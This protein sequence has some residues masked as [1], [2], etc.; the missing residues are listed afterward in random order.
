MAVFTGTQTGNVYRTSTSL[1]SGGEA[2]VCAVD[3]VP[4]LALK[5]YRRPTDLRRRKV[6]ALAQR[7][8][9]P[10]AQ[11]R[12]AW[13]LET[14]T[15]AQGRFAGFVMRRLPAGCVPLFK[16][17]ETQGAQKLGLTARDQIQVALSL[18]EA[19][20]EAHRL[21]V[22]IGD[23]NDENAVVDLGTKRVLLLDCDGY[24]FGPW[25]ATGWTPEG[26]APETHRSVRQKTGFYYDEYTDR[27]TLADHIF[28]LL[29]DGRGPFVCRTTD[30]SLNRPS[31]GQAIEE[32]AF[33]YD[34]P[35]TVAARYPAIGVPLGAPSYQRLS[36]DVR[37]LF[38]RAFTGLPAQRPTAV[39]WQNALRRMLGVLA[40]PN[41]SAVRH[42]PAKAKIT[43]RKRT[44]KGRRTQAW[45]NAAQTH[46]KPTPAKPKRSMPT[47]LRVSLIFF[48]A[49]LA[50]SCAS[51]GCSSTPHEELSPGWVVVQEG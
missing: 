39:E 7:L 1:G 47:A 24:V 37:A 22:S 45:K 10:G 48:A 51:H 46:Q 6:E 15:N 29:M 33:V 13:P 40:A 23:A 19:Y 42:T 9:S 12:F 41:P 43:S 32:G 49:A 2:T 16:V 26:S 11:N 50:L 20:G 27:F 8:P 28:R 25:E 34:L 17:Y 4:N 21:G 30:G 5:L 38:K 36:T 31:I 18:T 35:A 3:G 44:P 14:V